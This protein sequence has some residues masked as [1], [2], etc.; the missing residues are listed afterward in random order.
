MSLSFKNKKGQSIDLDVAISGFIASDV[1]ATF[2]DLILGLFRRQYA[3]NKPYKTFCDNSGLNPE[4]VG[5]W[6]AIPAIPAKAFKLAN[7]TCVPVDKATLVFH[8]SGTTNDDH[9]KHYMDITAEVI[10]GQSLWKAYDNFVGDDI[11]IIALVPAS[12]AAPNSSLSHMLGRLHTQ[13]YHWASPDLLVRSLDKVVRK[14]ELFCIFGT[15]FAFLEL[16]DFTSQSWK[17]PEGCKIVETGGFKG[18]TREITRNELYD[19]FSSRLGV[20]RENIIAEYGMSEMASQFYNVGGIGFGAPHWLRYRII[21][22]ITLDDAETGL[23]RVYD[24]ANWN[25]VAVI[26]T[27]DVAKKLPNGKFELLGRATDAE[28]RGCSLMVEERWLS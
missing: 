21:D 23:L 9:S 24:L 6:P 19:L 5:E 17:L 13:E 8:S 3:L 2:D 7:L 28:L 27:Q 4:N 1:I 14:N 25:S 10:Y 18:R 15:A 12:E 20:M 26:Q 22:P 11:P 16:F